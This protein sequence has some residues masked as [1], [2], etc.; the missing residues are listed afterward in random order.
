MTSWKVFLNNVEVKIMPVNLQ[1]QIK[2]NLLQIQLR[3]ITDHKLE[4]MNMKVRAIFIKEDKIGVTHIQT[5]L[6]TSRSIKL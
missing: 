2:L 3:T 4:W 1:E 6:M 5:S